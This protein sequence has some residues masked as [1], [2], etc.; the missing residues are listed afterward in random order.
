MGEVARTQREPRASTARLTTVTAA[1]PAQSPAAERGGWTSG[2]VIALIAGAFLALV[3]V[4]L[5]TGGAFLTWADL[6]QSHSG[7]L[8]VG[9]ASYSTPGYALASDPVKLNGG[10][11][12]LGRFVGD[13]QIRVTAADPARQVFAGIGPA[14]DVSRYLAGTSYSTVPVVGDTTVTEHAG[15]ALRAPPAQAVHW[16]AQAAGRGPLTLRWAT[17]SGTWLAVV[18]NADGSKNVTAKV[19]LAVSSPMMPWLAGELLA[20]AAFVAVPAALLI[21]VP[22]RRISRKE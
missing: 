17:Q 13:V 9:T 7:Y 12:W 8:T 6:T 16:V 3:S 20:A 11:G 2:R 10:W 5:L 15:L 19:E 4:G 18:M 1:L 22:A 14:A 21:I